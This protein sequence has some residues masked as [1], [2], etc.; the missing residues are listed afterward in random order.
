MYPERSRKS[1]NLLARPWARRSW[2]AAKPLGERALPTLY[3]GLLGDNLTASWKRF[4]VSLLCLAR[5]H[6]RLARRILRSTLPMGLRGS[7]GMNSTNDGV[8]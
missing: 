6:C 8:L 5:A 2:R 3:D 4:L 7:A 1:S